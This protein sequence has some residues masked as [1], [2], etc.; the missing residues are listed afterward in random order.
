VKVAGSNEIL[1]LKAAPDLL[2]QLKAA[3]GKTMILE[4]TLTPA[5]DAKTAVP[6]EVQSVR[7]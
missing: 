2:Q 7:P 3:M 5:K 4:G 6:L 1:T